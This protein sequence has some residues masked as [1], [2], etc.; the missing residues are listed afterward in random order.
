MFL[1]PQVGVWGVGGLFTCHFTF[2]A[3]AGFCRFKGQ[4]TGFWPYSLGVC[5]VRRPE[6]C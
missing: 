2:R 4:G 1:D 5:G 3:Q 6:A